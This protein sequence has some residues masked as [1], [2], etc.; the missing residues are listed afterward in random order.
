MSVGEY[1]YR[2]GDL[3]VVLNICQKGK[4]AIVRQDGVIEDMLSDGAHFGMQSLLSPGPCPSSAVA[5]SNCDIM[6]LSR[7]LISASMQLCTA[8]SAAVQK[9]F[10]ALYVPQ[11]I[12]RYHICVQVC[13][14]SYAIAVSASGI[15]SYAE[16]GSQV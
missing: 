6:S 7:D 8:S 4:V 2:E 16:S 12:Y 3:V 13:N 1:I 11:T 5:L 10:A 15:V 9:N 14:S